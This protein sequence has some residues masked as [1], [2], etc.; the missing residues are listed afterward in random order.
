MSDIIYIIFLMVLSFYRIVTGYNYFRYKNQN[1]NVVLGILM[2]E[3]ISFI[4][5]FISKNIPL[6]IPAF[7]MLGILSS[8]I[9]SNMKNTTVILSII[10]LIF[11]IYIVFGITKKSFI[12]KK[13]FLT[14]ITGLIFIINGICLVFIF[15]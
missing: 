5:L 6:T 9:F 7:L 3:I 1:Q 11:N 13:R 4:Y 15:I 8:E 10:Y 2:I 14:K 12:N